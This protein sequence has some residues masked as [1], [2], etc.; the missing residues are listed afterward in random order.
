LVT[1]SSYNGTNADYYTAK[2]AAADGALLWEQRYNGP[3][4]RTDEATA[5]VVDGSGNVVVAGY[6]ENGTNSDYCTAKYAATNG[7]LLWEK[8]YTGGSASS[9]ALGPNGMVAV[10]GTSS[11]DYATVVYWENLPPVSV[12]L[13]PTGVRIRFTGVPGHS[14]TI[15]RAPAVTGPWTTLATPSAPLGGLIEYA[16]TNAPAASAFYRTVQP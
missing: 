12:E 9:L 5:V 8:R 4:N 7:A 11:G 14:Y 3:S 1:G 13:V 2:Y 6:S 10:T 16:D 15:E